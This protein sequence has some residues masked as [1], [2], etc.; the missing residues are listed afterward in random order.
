MISM[1]QPSLVLHSHNVPGYKYQMW[2]TWTVPKSLS[3]SSL[4]DWIVSA[5]DRSPEMALKNIIINTHG[6]PGYLHIGSGVGVKDLNEFKRLRGKS[7]GYIWVIACEVSKGVDLGNVCPVDEYNG[8]YFCTELAKASGTFVVA[9]EELQSVDPGFTVFS[10]FVPSGYVDDYEGAVYRYS[11]A[12]GRTRIS[13][14][15]S[16]AYD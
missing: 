1:K 6:S 14:N 13:A 8:P 9:S 12:G 2:A 15:G 11:P 7:I 4:V 10:V 16:D 5:V 3:A